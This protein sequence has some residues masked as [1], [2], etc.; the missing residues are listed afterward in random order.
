MIK[1]VIFDL[2]GTLLY[3][4]DSI[5]LS[6]NKV[7]AAHHLPPVSHEQ[8]KQFV[9]DGV[10]DLLIRSFYAGGSTEVV[11]HT[12]VSEFR[13]CFKDDC[14]FNVKPYDGIEALISWLKDK[15]IYV[16]CNT[17]KPH[18][19]AVKLIHKHFSNNFD[20]IQGQEDGV[21]KKPDKTGA[22]QIIKSLGV[23]PEEVV[24]IGD[25][26]VDIFTAKNAGLYSIG[27]AWGYR[28]EKELRLSGAQFIAHTPYEVIEIL[29]MQVE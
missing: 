19:N 8:L 3:T 27:A 22:L 20:A 28:G 7:L 15:G 10:I 18:E 13:A 11:N 4:L 9:G 24:Y 2:D 26:N 29:K 6:C 14:D 25:S 17:N 1:A 23:N 12:T 5:A 16:A 21:P